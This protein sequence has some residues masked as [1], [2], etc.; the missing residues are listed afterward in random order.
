MTRFHLKLITKTLR[1][2]YLIIKD[3]NQKTNEKYELILDPNT[4]A[5]TMKHS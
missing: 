1:R 4:D 5:H 3:F 2:N